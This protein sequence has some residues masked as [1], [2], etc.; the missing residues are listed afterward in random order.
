ME[1]LYPAFSLTTHQHIILNFG[2]QPW[3]YEP[4]LSNIVNSSSSSQTAIHPPQWNGFNK[5]SI[6]SDE[7]RNQINHWLTHRHIRYFKMDMDINN[8]IENDTNN[9]NISSSVNDS[10]EED[11]WDGP[12]CTMCFNE[13]KN[14]KVLPCGHGIWGS[15][16]TKMLEYW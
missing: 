4:D 7:F 14:T 13:P 3:I 10:K 5:S 2:D 6:M 9:Q 11:D 15:T 16:C 8:H 12:L 1:G